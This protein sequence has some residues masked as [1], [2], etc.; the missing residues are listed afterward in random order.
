MTYAATED[1]L[2]GAAP[3]T[4][5]R[6]EYGN[7]TWAYADGDLDITRFGVD[8]TSAVIGRSNIEQGNP[9]LDRIELQIESHPNLPLAAFYRST[10]PSGRVSVKLFQGHADLSPSDFVTVWVGT[11]ISFQETRPFTTFV[12]EPAYAALRRNG[13]RRTFQVQC[14]HA[15]FNPGCNASRAA[16]ERS[17]AV[18]QVGVNFLDL[19]TGWEGTLPTNKYRSGF[20]SFT[21]SITGALDH[22]P[23]I[24]IR[25]ADNKRVVLGGTVSGVSVG[26][27]IQI[28][29]GCN[30][31]MN[32]CRDI[33]NNLKNFGGF[34]WIPL[35]KPYGKRH[36]F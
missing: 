27:T 34:P 4:L 14:P 32:D 12:C 11:V 35:E 24:G 20:V 18:T 19:E 1:S 17:V 9:G 31:R 26:D 23:V 7:L 36:Q 33:F 21:S 30:K 13:L 10:P 8:Y 6:F 5:Y 25:G 3:V 29:P 15:L 16:V 2:E 22:L 28:Y